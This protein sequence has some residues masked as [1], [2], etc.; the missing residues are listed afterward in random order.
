MV[1]GWF[2]H[3][4][5]IVH[6]IFNLTLPLIWQ[7]VQQ[8]VG[9]TSL[10]EHNSPSSFLNVLLSLPFSE[11][12]FSGL[13]GVLVRHPHCML[14]LDHLAHYNCSLICIFHWIVSCLR[15]ALYSQH[16]SQC[17]EHSRSSISICWI[18]EYSPGSSV[19]KQSA[20][21]VGGPGSVLGSGR[22]SGE[23]NGNPLQNSCLENPT[24]RGAWW[25]TVHGVTKSRT[26]LCD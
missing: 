13:L 12:S 23:G 14:N 10:L 2:K 21:Y 4:T 6:F 15:E 26:Q 3:I 18:Y 8:L 24:D 9:L 1:S 19:S 16:L 11:K 17:L 7:E 25:A 22:F 20:Y 5:F